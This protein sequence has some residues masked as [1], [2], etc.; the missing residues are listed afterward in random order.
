M[1]EAIIPLAEWCAAIVETLGIGM[2]TFSAIY[3][4]SWGIAQRIKTGDEKSALII[5]QKIRQRMGRGILLG[6]EFLIAADIIHT[7]AVEFTYEA[8]GV[9][10]LIVL[11]RTFLSITLELE[12]EGRWPW[13]KKE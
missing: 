10:A 11:I 3:S 2:I 1:T 12:I 5:W 9:L 7:V 13:Q 6:L 4:L 8:V